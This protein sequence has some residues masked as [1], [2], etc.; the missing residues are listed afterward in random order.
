MISV[1]GTVESVE[2]DAFELNL[3]EDMP[4]GGALITVE[5]DDGDRDADAYKLLP[6]DGS[7]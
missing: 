1:T 4:H 2:A 6:G 3:A 5:M 7:E